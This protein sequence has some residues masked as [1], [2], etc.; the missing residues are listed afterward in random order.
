[1]VKQ[2]ESSKNPLRTLKSER[3]KKSDPFF[4]VYNHRRALRARALKRLKKQTL[5]QQ[6]K[7]IQEEK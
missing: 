7:L 6:N 3:P 5:K 1:M 2:Q 4:V